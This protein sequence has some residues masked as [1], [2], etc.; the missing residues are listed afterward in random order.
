MPLMAHIAALMSHIDDRNQE[1]T[2][3]YAKLLAS[4]VL[5]LQIIFS[6]SQILRILTSFGCKVIF[7]SAKTSFAP[8][9]VIHIRK[10]LDVRNFLVP[11]MSYF[12]KEI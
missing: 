11:D 10:A 8:P 7:F 4:F 3:Y 9:S 5:V 2:I 1:W 12:A 6:G